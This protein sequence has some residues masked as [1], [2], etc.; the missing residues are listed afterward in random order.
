MLLSKVNN[1][2]IWKDI[3]GYEELYKI[4]NYG[5]VKSLI[6]NHNKYREKIL[7]PRKVGQ[8]NYLNIM[9]YKNKIGKS[10]YI[11][12]LV[13]ETFVGLCPDGMECRHLDNNPQNNKL[14]NLQW[15]TPKINQSDRILNGTSNIGSGCGTSKLNNIAV[16]IIK[17][18]LETKYLTQT[19]ISKIFIVSNATISLIKNKKRWNHI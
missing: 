15:S 6:N 13:L 17:R 7:M 11:H 1:I 18:L 12:R 16:R 10:F 14:D 4:S 5:K 9:L 19:E 3:I 8:F 2:E